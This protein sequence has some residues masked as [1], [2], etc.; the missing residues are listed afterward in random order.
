M[1]G[2]FSS[3]IG[4]IPHLETLLGTPCG[5]VRGRRQGFTHVAGWGLKPTAEKARRYAR[6][7]GLPYISLE[8]GFIRSLG[9]GVDGA[10]PHSL[11]VDFTGIYYD[12]TRPSDL[13]NLIREAPFAED[14]LERARACMGLIRQYRLSK[15][16]HA[17]DRMASQP[18]ALLPHDEPAGDQ[19]PSR[20]GAAGETQRVLVVDQTVGDASIEYGLADAGSFARMLEAA[21]DENPGAEI[22]VKTHPDVLAGKKEGYLPALAEQNG[23]R[24][25]GE[26]VSPWALLD[27]VDSVYVVTSQLGFE[28][29]MAGKTVRCFGMPFYAGWGLTGD[30]QRCERRG[31]ERS[32]EQVFAAAYL[33]YCRYINP[34]TGQR[35]ELEDTIA[36]IS[37]QKRVRDRFRGDWLALGMSGHKRRFVGRFL[38][39]A[40][41]VRFVAGSGREEL[42]VRSEEWEVRSEGLGVRSE[43]LGVRG[44]QP[45]GP[46]VLSWASRTGSELETACAERGLGLYRAEDGFVRSVGL[47][48]DLVDPLSLVIDS[49][50]IYYD[51]S[52]PSDLESLLNEASLSA[53]LVN[54]AARLRRRLVDLK[55]SKYNVGAEERLDLPGDR[56]IILVPGQVESDASIATGAIGI[57]TNRGLLEAVR[58]ANPEAFVI[59]KP[60]PDVASGGRLGEVD[61]QADRLCD[62]EVTDIAMPRLL[63][64]VD[65]VHTMTSLTG[66]EAL[67]RGLRV[68]THGLPFYAG[69]GLTEDRVTCERRG[70]QLTLDELVAATLILYPV[71]VDPRS[72]DVVNAETAV[73]LLAAR[74]DSGYRLSLKSRLYRLF[75]RRV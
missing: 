54:R 65:E 1:I 55:L 29:L 19:E 50:G 41:R 36:L 7:H 5:P 62:L 10:P 68:V 3:G 18:D 57:K 22:L 53:D 27:Q 58:D 12:A 17:P 35:C 44:H 31:V 51:A 52:R 47:G 71:Y 69:W 59:Y 16:N 4:R 63:E 11:I 70:R 8:D 48:V 74:R 34:Y 13:E 14:E 72:G 64:Q 61:H 42:G 24:L 75:R 9:L 66:F 6:K 67:L 28:A 56:R 23:C 38:G 37:D 25:V 60:H 45:S 73:E 43:G 21:V 30:E 26:D 39:D 46:R 40:A 20:L 49:Q 15:Y 2:Y 33:R 32:L